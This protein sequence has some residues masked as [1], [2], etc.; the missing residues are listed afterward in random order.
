MSFGVGRRRIA[1][2]A[3]LWIVAAVAL[4][5]LTTRALDWFAKDDEL[6]Y[7]RLAISIERTHSLVPTI[8]GVDVGSYS[9]LYPLLI[10]P[11]FRHGLVPHDVRTVHLANAWIMSSACIPVYF[12]ARRVTCRSWAAYLAAALT[13]LMPW[14]LLSAMMMTEVAAYPAFAWAL[15]AI[16]RALVAPSRRNDLLALAAIGLAYFARGEL[17]VLL[18]VFP[19]AV[20]AY[21]ARLGERSLARVAHR[22]EL[23][24]GASAAVVVAAIAVQLTGGL[25]RLAGVYGRYAKH[26]SLFPHGIAG[27]FV[28]H[29]ATFSLAFGVLPF[30][31]AVAWLLANAARPPGDPDRAA[32]A[33]IGSITIA[34]VVFQ[35]TN[36]DVLY[37][38]FVHDR[39]LVYLVP[40]VVIAVL[41][42]SLDAAPLRWSLALPAAL[43]ALGFAIGEIP[44]STWGQFAT[45][46]DDAI[47]GA[48]YKPV[49]QAFGGL[50]GA[51]V[52]LEL[53]AVL[54]SV[55]LLLGAW[56]RPRLRTTATLAVVLVLALPTATA[57][58]FARFFG[59]NDWASR[60]I[61]NPQVDQF[62]WV[63]KAVGRNAVVTIATYPVSSSW[64]VNFRVWRDYQ[65]WN[66]SIDR[67]VERPRGAF[68]FSSFWFPKIALGFDPTTG[69]ADVSPS[70]YVLEADQESRFRIAGKELVNSPD[71]LRLIHADLPWRA[72]WLSFGLYDDGWTRPGVTAHVRVYAFP[73]QSRPLIRSLGFGLRAPDGVSARPF[74]L[75]SN[76]GVVRGSASQDTLFE[77]IRVCVPPRGFA[78]VLLRVPASSVIPGDLATLDSSLRSRVGGLF[79]SQ[80]ALADELGGSCHP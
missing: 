55:L 12:L 8:H 48:L 72:D 31:G 4:S 27:S 40:I 77:E 30:V 25:S 69:R 71:G 68:S 51:R 46:D 59:N 28:E 66:A 24:A 22:H 76:E 41:C 52:A 49:A 44:F 58:A 36:F 37:N 61:T 67:D 23:L 17:L 70:P 75:R 39:F 74:V 56:L 14:I 19:V 54:G 57:Y 64:F 34:A 33:W 20:V 45:I 32:F 62:A 6:R 35:S 3:L 15:L 16:Q 7:E 78:E 10:A 73:H 65:Y 21:E 38:A 53:F 43:V 11:F 63:D 13:V 29:L 5:E 60:P 47:S 2:L 80:I 9:Q 79:L 18:I 50:S 42:A 26:E 1:S